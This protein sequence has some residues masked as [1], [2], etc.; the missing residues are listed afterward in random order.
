MK[1]YFCIDYL[2]AEKYEPYIRAAVHS[3][4][5]NANLTPIC[6]CYDPDHKLRADIVDFFEKKGVKLI[7]AVPRVLA[8][9]RQIGMDLSFMSEST[10][11]GAYLRFEVPLIETEDEFVLYTDC[12][13]LFTGP[14]ELDDLRPKYFA[15]APEFYK[16]KW[17][18]CN[19]GVM[20]MNVPAMRATSNGL[21]AMTIARWSAHLFWAFDQGDINAFY[22]Q[23]W[24]HLPLEYNWKPYWGA[25][26]EAR[27]VHFHG[28]KPNDVV[29]MLHQTAAHPVIYHNLLATNPKGY[30]HFMGLYNQMLIASYE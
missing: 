29:T 7:R 2:G 4:I 28:P 1:W 11:S 18:Y 8:L 22:F 24:D 6:L 16:D 27:V 21:I 20:L 17:D 9:A 30:V 15:C 10:A 26:S 12:D 5:I 13:V 25:N 19:T 23:G 3:A 14:V